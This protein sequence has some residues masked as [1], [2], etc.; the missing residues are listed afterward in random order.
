[1]GGTDGPGAGLGRARRGGTRSV[2]AADGGPVHLRGGREAVRGCGDH[3]AVAPGQGQGA[4]RQ[5][6]AGVRRGGRVNGDTV[7]LL[8]EHDRARQAL[9]EAVGWPGLESH[10]AICPLCRKLAAWLDRLDQM[11]PK[12]PP[13]RPGLLAEL[14][15]VTVGIPDPRP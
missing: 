4:P 9:L 15:M 13:P 8:E 2:R 14:M 7:R 5:A 11:T 6:A 10:L 1:M 3:D 12:I